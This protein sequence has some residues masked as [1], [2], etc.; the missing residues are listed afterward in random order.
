MKDLKTFTYVHIQSSWGFVCCWVTDEHCLQAIGK[1]QAPVNPLVLRRANYFT[2]HPVHSRISHSEWQGWHQPAVNGI[3]WTVTLVQ[4]A[5]ETDLL[6]S[7]TL[8][9]RAN[10]CFLWQGTRWF[11]DEQVCIS[12]LT[13]ERFQKQYM[14]PLFA[15][16]HWF[17]GC[18]NQFTQT[19]KQ[20]NA[21]G[22]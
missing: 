20:L 1:L 14:K 2:N 10:A 4:L 3:R 22:S 18:H 5:N 13:A 16:M 7:E 12:R 19:L 11:A 15:V 9:L 8:A 17:N 6:G 21:P